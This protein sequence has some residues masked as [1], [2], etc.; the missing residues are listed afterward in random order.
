[1]S[2]LISTLPNLAKLS[3]ESCTI[4]N[5]DL[6]PHLPSNLKSLIIENCPNLY[7]EDFTPFLRTHGSQLKT[8]ILNHN[9]A[10]NISF[11][12]ILR[13]ACPQ[14]QFLKMELNY[15]NTHS[16]SNDSDPIYLSLLE[17]DEIPRWPKTLQHL[18]MIHLRSWSHAAAENFFDSLIK[19]ANGELPDLRVLILKAILNINWRERASFRDK[20]EGKF[21]KVFLRKPKPPGLHLQSFKAYR[22][23]LNQPKVVIDTGN[24]AETTTS[25]A[26][27]AEADDEPVPT[28]RRTLRPRKTPATHAEPDSEL[29]GSEEGT[30]NEDDDLPVQ[31][32]CRIIDIRIDNLRPRESQFTEGDFLDS[33]HS[34]DEEWNEGGEV[35]GDD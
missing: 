11:L 12:P 18:E 23:W 4:V 30:S 1:M 24:P 5:G 35:M 3:F 21:R 28:G 10:L 16:T 32:M 31:G 20:T 29:S 8:L 26:S 19:S 14:L 17:D 6:I 33:E 22:E 2:N 34:G 7:S 9:Q 27:P 25:S 15:Y 13:D